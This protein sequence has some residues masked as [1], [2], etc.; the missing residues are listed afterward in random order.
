MEAKRISAGGLQFAYLS[1]GEGPLALCLHGFPDSAHTWDGLL[2]ALAER[3]FRAVAPWMRGYAPTSVPGD[4]RY[5]AGALV[6]DA[7]ALH[8]A[9][10]GDQEAVIIGHDWGAIAAYGAAASAPERWRRVITLAIPP[11]A[12]TA[13]ALFQYDQLRLFWYQF[14]FNLPLAEQVVAH[15]DFRLIDRLWADWSPGFDPGALLDYAK[16]ALR[17]EGHLA[18]ALGYY[19]ALYDPTGHDPELAKLQQALLGPVPQ[20]TLYLHGQR[21][22]CISPTLG[23]GAEEYLGPGSRRLLVPDAGHFLHLESPELVSR[24]IL[25]FLE[26]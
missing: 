1:A 14:L 23:E 13:Q 6:A 3:G 21:D 5:Q 17:P 19:R 25:E 9:L 4:G 8:D 20:P 2:P 10:G 15:E 16:Q 22:G 12:L 11:T 26:G 18:A 24:A 7:L